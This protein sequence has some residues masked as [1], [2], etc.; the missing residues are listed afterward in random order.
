MDKGKLFK[1]CLVLFVLSVGVRLLLWQSNKVAMAE[2]QYG[3]TDLY[4]DDARTLLRGD[5]KTFL[6]GPNPP[7]DATTLLH[8]PGYPI[9]IAA[10]YGIFGESEAYRIVQILI[11]SLASI[12]FFLI[13]AC[14]FDLKTAVIAGG[15]RGRGAAV[16]LSFLAYAAG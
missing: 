9:L 12:L 10:V 1:I 13:A 16:C 8:P 7:S 2:V 6:A 3:P 5:L 11:C 15:F 14:L 4:K